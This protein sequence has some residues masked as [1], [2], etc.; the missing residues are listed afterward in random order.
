MYTDGVYDSLGMLS[1]QEEANVR[2]LDPFEE[3]RD[4]LYDP[5]IDLTTGTFDTESG[6]IFYHHL[7]S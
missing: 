1:L 5:E 6:S 4:I 7:T 2:K 3:R